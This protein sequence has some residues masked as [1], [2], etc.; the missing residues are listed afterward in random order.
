MPCHQ[1]T[2][3][4]RH[5][6]SNERNYSVLPHQKANQIR[7]AHLPTH[8]DTLE[9]IYREYRTKFGKS[10]FDFMPETFILPDD[11]EDLE[12]AMMANRETLWIMKKPQVQ[13]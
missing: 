8:K 12:K 1:C 9:R 3:F 4:W 2:A 6:S 7:L 11:R 10:K 13:H 5:V